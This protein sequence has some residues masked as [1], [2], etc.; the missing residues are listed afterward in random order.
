VAS[1][2][3]SQKWARSFGSLVRDEIE[4]KQQEII[5][6]TMRKVGVSRVLECTCHRKIL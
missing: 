4:M 6:R 2:S 1:E 3:G 5:G